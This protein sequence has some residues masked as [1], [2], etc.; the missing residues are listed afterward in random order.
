[1]ANAKKGEYGM[2]KEYEKPKADM[3]SFQVEE[4]LMIE[5]EVDG[6]FD[7]NIGGGTEL[8]PGLILVDD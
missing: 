8:P 2:K 6:S 7:G 3:V 4:P 5:G 1:M